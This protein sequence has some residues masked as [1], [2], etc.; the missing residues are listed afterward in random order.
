M[1]SFDLSTAQA[2]SAEAGI[3]PAIVL[4]LRQAIYGHD[5]LTLADME[6][7][8]A[9]ARK[10]GPQ[11]C[12]EWTSFFSEALTDYLVH[13]NTP[14]DYIPQEKAD[15]LVSNLSR[16]GGIGSRAEFA[17]LIDVMTHALGVPASLSAFALREIKAAIIDGRRNAFHDE[18]HP[19]GVVTRPDVEALRAVLYAA[20][21]GT[22]EHVTQEEAEALFDIAHATA[23]AQNDPSFDELFA[24]AVGNYLMAINLDVPDAAEALHF[25]KWLDEEESLPRFLS[26][27]LHRAPAGGSFNVL[28]S[29]A[30]AYE[31]DLARRDTAEAARRDESEKIG[32]PKAAWV[33]AHLTRDGAL[34]SS[35]TRLLQFLGAEAATVAPSLQGLI[36]KARVAGAR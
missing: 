14:C 18:D 21:N 3:D 13:Q 35:E 12:P 6:L 5:Q 22:A 19:A 9:V 27:L 4:Q 33:I 25:E 24:R 29:P 11:S 32:E 34:T 36:D 30:Q 8:L 2:L 15:W 26:G 10:A 17:M 28:K 7:V 1:T 23:Q 20:K 31:T 16:N